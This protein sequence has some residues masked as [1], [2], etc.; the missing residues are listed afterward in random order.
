MKP[1]QQKKTRNCKQASRMNI[2][3]SSTLLKDN[4][5]K[6]KDYVLILNDKDYHRYPRAKPGKCQNIYYRYFVLFSCQK[7]WLVDV[8]I[9]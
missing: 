7:M 3:N 8:V 5:D 9:W 2:K 4:T 1:I 6:A